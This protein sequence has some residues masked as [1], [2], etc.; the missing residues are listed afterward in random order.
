MS[1]ELSSRKKPTSEFQPCCTANAAQGSSNDNDRVVLTA[2]LDVIEGAVRSGLDTVSAIHDH[3]KTVHK[4]A[5]MQ[6]ADVVAA[7]DM[8]MERS[9]IYKIG[10]TRFAA[11]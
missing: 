10:H 2:S 5:N 6:R 4:T 9:V 1:E 8:L 11:I 7:L 3:L